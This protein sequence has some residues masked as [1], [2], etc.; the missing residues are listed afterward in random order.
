MLSE[1]VAEDLVPTKSENEP[2]F[3]N[4]LSVSAPDILESQSGGPVPNLLEP[5]V[6]DDALYSM[7]VNDVACTDGTCNKRI[8]CAGQEWSAGR[9]GN[10]PIGASDAARNSETCLGHYATRT[11]QPHMGCN[12]REDQASS[13]RLPREKDQ[14]NTSQ[15][16]ASSSRRPAAAEDRTS[17]ATVA[18]HPRRPPY[19]CGR[20][21]DDVHVWTSIIDRWLSTVQGKPSMQLTYVVSLLRGAAIEW[22]TLMETRTG[23]PGDWT[24]LRHAMLERFGS[25][26]RAGKARAALLQMTQGKMPVLEY[27]DAFESYLAQ[28]DDYDESFFLAKFILGLR[29]SILTQVIV[30]HPATLLEAK[31]IAEE[32]ELTQSMVKVHQREKKTAKTAQHRGTQERQSGR[33][34]QSVQRIQMK[35]CRNKIRDRYQKTDSFRD[36]GCV[37]A[38]IGAREVSCPDGHGPAAVWRSMLRDLPQGD[39]AGHV[40]RQGSIV[41]IDLEALMRRRDQRLSADTTVA[42]MSMHPPSGRPRAARVYLW[43]RLL[44][45]DRERRARDHVRERH[46]VTSLLETLVSPTSGGTKSCEGVTPSR[47]QD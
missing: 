13:R 28:L 42:A 30:Q 45:R 33:L 35:T 21:D 46:Y 36:R 9:P 37:S 18:L 10:R 19:F 22:Y 26:I 7:N 1:G 44:R 29:P 17:P 8:S 25:S 27:F 11:V 23:C 41:T 12:T 6:D 3:F 15:L 38:H 32:L 2:T 34:R 31:G 39:R 47:S 4:S 40:R 43:N 24:M 5:G 14:D 20:K 16:R